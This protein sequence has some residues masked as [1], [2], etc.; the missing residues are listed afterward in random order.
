M[1]MNINY[2]VIN[3]GDAGQ[4]NKHDLPPPVDTELYFLEIY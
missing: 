4:E 1:N 3:G 2:L